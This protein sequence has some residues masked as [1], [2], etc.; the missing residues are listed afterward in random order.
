MNIM[1]LFNRGPSVVK[2]TVPVYVREGKDYVEMM[3]PRSLPDREV[4]KIAIQDGYVRRT[5][6][7]GHVFE[8]LAVKGTVHESSVVNITSRFLT[9]TI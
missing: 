9:I 5:T 3:R 4:L 6:R 1:N 2:K 8:R 7:D